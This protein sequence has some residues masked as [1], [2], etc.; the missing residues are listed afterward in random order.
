MNTAWKVS[1]FIVFLVRIFTHSGWIRTRKTPFYAVKMH[2]TYKNH[3][4]LS[5]YSTLENHSGFSNHNYF[6]Q[7]CFLLRYLLPCHMN[8]HVAVI[9]FWQKTKNLVLEQYCI[10]FT[11]LRFKWATIKTYFRHYWYESFMLKKGV[12]EM[13]SLFPCTPVIRECSW[14]KTQIGK[15]KKKLYVLRYTCHYTRTFPHSC[16]YLRFSKETNFDEIN[17]ISCIKN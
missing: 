14:R 8:E 13:P 6:S 12:K 5:K 2:S 15:K 7:R 3:S 4:T 1:L 17:N 10:V 16:A 11:L 9:T